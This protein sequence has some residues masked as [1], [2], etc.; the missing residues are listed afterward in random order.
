MYF[1]DNNLTPQLR[2]TLESIGIN[3]CREQRDVNPYKA[4]EGAGL[5][6]QLVKED[7]G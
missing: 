3:S 1:I 5:W 6:S 7:V 4:N 2:H